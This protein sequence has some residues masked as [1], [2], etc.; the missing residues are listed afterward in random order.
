MNISPTVVSVRKVEIGGGQPCICVPVIGKDADEILK[1]TRELCRKKPDLIEWRADFFQEIS[2][3]EKVLDV[4]QYMRGMIG[5]IPLLFTIRSEKEGG[6]PIP[7]T[8]SEKISLMKRVCQTRQVDLIDH[9]LW[10]ERNIPVIRNV[11][12]EYGVRLILSFHDFAQ[13]P[14]KE[15]LVDK[16]LKAGEFGADIAKVAVMPVTFKDVIVLMGATEEARH[17]VRIPLITMSMGGLGTMTRLA[18][19]QY[20]SAVTF[21]AGSRCSAPGQMPVEEVQNLLPVIRKYTRG[22]D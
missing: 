8:D 3:P 15:V 13:T 22:E 4:V 11:S 14:S 7:L 5:E 10:D 9:E 16:I 19:W 12:K 18:G 20:G 17:H 1:Q 21:A 6:Q 2:D